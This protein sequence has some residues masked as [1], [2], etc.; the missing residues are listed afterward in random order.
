MNRFPFLDNSHLSYNYSW[1]STPRG[2]HL[3]RIAVLV[4]DRCMMMLALKS[5]YVKQLFCQWGEPMKNRGKTYL[6]GARIDDFLASEGLQSMK[7]SAKI[8]NEECD[9]E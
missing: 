9:K 2:G 1:P 4:V 3:T 5:K 8:K 6:C 7:F